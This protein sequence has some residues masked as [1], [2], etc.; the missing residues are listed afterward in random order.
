MR[1]IACFA[2]SG[3]HSTPGLLEAQ[4]HAF[5]A[6]FAATI[7]FLAAFNFFMRHV[8]SDTKSCFHFGEISPLRRTFNPA[9]RKKAARMSQRPEGGRRPM[10]VAS[11]L[12][13]GHRQQSKTTFLTN[14]LFHLRLENGSENIYFVHCRRICR[15][16]QY[17]QSPPAGKQ[18]CRQ[19][20]KRE[21]Q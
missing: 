3:S 9:R 13:Y 14:D 15:P 18:F 5:L 19:Q 11:L 21:K 4:F 16:E 7:K 17:Q 6:T 10:P 8:S 1:N 12:A 20:V 2:L